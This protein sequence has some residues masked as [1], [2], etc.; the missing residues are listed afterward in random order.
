MP[1]ILI[2]TENYEYGGLEKFLF[3]VVL[4]LNRRHEILLIFNEDNERIKNFAVKN[5]LLFEGV[6]I[7]TFL[8]KSGGA[9]DLLWPARRY[10]RFILNYFTLKKFFARLRGY[11]CLY[12]VNGGYPGADGCRI[13][14]MLA[15][16]QG[17]KKVI[18]VVLSCPMKTRNLFIAKQLAELIDG[19]VRNG[20]SLFQVNCEKT[21]TE[22]AEMKNFSADK[23]KVVYTG[24]TLPSAVGKLESVKINGTGF[25]R[26]DGDIWLGMVSFMDGLKGHKYL[27]QA[28][29]I[30]LA[31]HRIKC[32]LIG[33]G[34]EY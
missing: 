23:I 27:V 10:I 8:R 14:S 16:K 6:K 19:K 17:I 20:V 32:L 2:F 18:H 7:E 4:H 13:V 24:I 15:R 31:S 28:M 11:D 22:M 25:A 34:P 26:N 1:K 9:I 3:E 29:K 5:K 33:D 12:V 21:K 30:V